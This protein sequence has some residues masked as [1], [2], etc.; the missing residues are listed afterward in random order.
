VI[1]VRIVSVAAEDRLTS[2]ATSRAM[3]ALPRVKSTF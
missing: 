1:A 2:S 3:R